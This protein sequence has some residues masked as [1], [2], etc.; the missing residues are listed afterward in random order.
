[1]KYFVFA[2]V[3]V[4]ALC[5]TAAMAQTQWTEQYNMDYSPT[6]AAGTVNGHTLQIADLAGNGTYGPE[7][8]VYSGGIAEFLDDGASSG[9]QGLTSGNGSAWMQGS[10]NYLVEF[11]M[12]VLGDQQGSGDKK[13]MSF[14]SNNG[15]GLQM[16]NASSYFVNGSGGVA[17][18]GDADYDNWQTYRVVVDGSVNTAYL[19]I[20]NGGGWLGLMSTTLGGSGAWQ[21]AGMGFALGS[22]SGSHTTYSHF[23]MDYYKVV[24][25]TTNVNWAPEPPAPTPE[26]GSLLALGSGLIGMAG[27][28][29]R[30]RRA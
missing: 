13:S 5:A 9:N 6:I 29:I 19:Y 14:W 25:G 17:G 3:L 20:N 23:Y 8:F 28:A 1:M 11:R 27:F 7:G 18:A 4:F 15:R 26:P 12:K 2:L 30:R 10:S 22:T 16:N 24:S 21:T